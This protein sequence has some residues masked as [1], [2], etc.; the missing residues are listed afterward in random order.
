MESIKVSLF[1]IFAYTLPGLFVLVGILILA[2]ES[3]KNI[4]DL[5]IMLNNLG[6]GSSA[7]AVLTAFVIGF[8]VDS[9]GN[10]YYR[11]SCKIGENPMEDTR[12][13]FNIDRQK[14]LQLQQIVRD[15][16]PSVNALLQT[17]R[18]LKSVSRNLAFTFLLLTII[19]LLK[20]NF[21]V[22]GNSIEWYLLSGGC[23]VLSLILTGRAKRFDKWFYQDLFNTGIALRLIVLDDGLKG[24]K[25]LSSSDHKKQYHKVKA[26]DQQK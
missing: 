22:V 18:L 25:T 8:A 5:T 20:T 21:F 2:D 1:D 17:W 12:K 6:I 9:L 3:I 19:T 23:F 14:D 15:K 4:V 11:F 10:L 7:M 24:I 16:S 13:E 26:K